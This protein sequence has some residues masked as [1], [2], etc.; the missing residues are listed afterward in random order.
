MSNVFTFFYKFINFLNFKKTLNF[1][2]IF[3]SQLK[4]NEN[5]YEKTFFSKEKQTC[6]N[7][8]K[9]IKLLYLFSKNK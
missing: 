2:F 6:F 9:N 1:F 8:F 3:K 5:C 4:K 7:Q